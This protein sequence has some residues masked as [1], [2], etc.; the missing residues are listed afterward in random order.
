MPSCTS[1]NRRTSFTSVCVYVRAHVCAWKKILNVII[2]SSATFNIFIITL[3]MLTYSLLLLS[4]H[5][6]I[7]YCASLLIVYQFWVFSCGGSWVSFLKHQIF[8]CQDSVLSQPVSMPLIS[9]FLIASLLFPAVP[10]IRMLS[11]CVFVYDFI[12][13][14]LLPRFYFNVESRLV[15][16]HLCFRFVQI[17]FFSYKHL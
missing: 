7:A 2:S 5:I 4:F 6:L 16:Y 13:N 8:L 1:E 11:V 10:W 15:V 17:C 14:V 3:H 9:C 12:G